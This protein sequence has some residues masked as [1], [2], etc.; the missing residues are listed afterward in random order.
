MGWNIYRTIIRL[1]RTDP[2]DAEI[3]KRYVLIA[4]SLL[5]C[6]LL[7][8]SAISA[9]DGSGC[10]TKVSFISLINKKNIVAEIPR[11]ARVKKQE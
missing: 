4:V 11:P 5:T 9:D 10:R 2:A 7:F 8:L 1:N 3:E 6:G